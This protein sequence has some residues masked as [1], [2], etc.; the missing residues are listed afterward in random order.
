VRALVH[1]EGLH[2]RGF[3]LV[4]I[5]AVVAIMSLTVAL[6]FPSLISG[7]GRGGLKT[8]A[9]K[10]A[11]SLEYSRNRALRE[12]VAYYV[13][14]SGRRLLVRR[15]GARTPEVEIEGAKNI[16]VASAGGGAIVFFPSGGSSGGAL[17]VSDTKRETYYNIKVE[18]STGR[19]RVSSLM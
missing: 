5:L 19:V 2:E 9:R 8:T 13:E 7:L 11:A 3:T 14:A 18:P 10:M 6:V 16:E 12:R 4:E 17:K 1:E 15:A